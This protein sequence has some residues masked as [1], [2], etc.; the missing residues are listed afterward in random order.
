MPVLAGSAAYAVGEARDWPVG[1]SRKVQ[2][3]KAFYAFLT[4]PEGLKELAALEAQLAA[5]SEP[6]AA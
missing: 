2:E 1:F 4:G 6:V 5:L 3:A